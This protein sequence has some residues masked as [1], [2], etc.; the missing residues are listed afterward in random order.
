VAS[1]TLTGRQIGG[2]ILVAAGAL[3]IASG[4]LINPVVSRLLKGSAA[5]D[6][7]DV[8]RSYFLWSWGLGIATVWMGRRVGRATAKSRLD[9]LSVLLLMVAGMILFDRFLLTRFGLTLW[10]HDPELHYQHRPGIERTLALVGRPNDLVRINEWGHHDTDLPKDKPE[11]QLRGIALGDSV[12]MGYGLTYAET[13]AAQLE[14]KLAQTDRSHSS[15][16]LINTGV[17]GYA[18]FQ[19]LRVLER[20]L[21]FS[22]DY[23]VLGFCLNDV[24]EPFVVDS[25]LGGT[26]LDY[27]GVSQS[28]S[29]LMGWLAN[30]TGIGRLMQKLAERGRTKDEETRLELYNVRAMIE[31]SRTEPRFQEAWSITLAHL[32]QLYAVAAEHDL[33]VLVL[34]FPFTFQLADESLRAPQEILAEH[35]KAHG[36]DLIDMAPPFAEAVFDD[37]ELVAFLKARGDTP[38]Q[39]ESR[40]VGRFSEL[41]FDQ[42]HFTGAGNALVADAIAG[43][44]VQRGLVD[45]AA[46]N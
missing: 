8:Q 5:I 30:E 2:G 6:V 23:V 24:T 9:G 12:T 35:A 18:T 32:E 40:F 26:G 37:P 13:F 20:S 44:L 38:E 36:V 42:D 27:H 10:K 17:H 16:E 31:G 46:A 25:N 15:H 45:A 14:A 34:V 21:E 7:A 41:F 4:V 33:P 1:V 22:P 39:I 43:W 28:P 19:E 3:M 11:G 29:R